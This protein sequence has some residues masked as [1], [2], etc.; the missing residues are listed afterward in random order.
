MNSRPRILIGVYV[1]NSE[2]DRLL[3]GKRCDEGTW[4]VLNKKLGYGETF[5]D[6]AVKLLSSTANILV[7]PERLRFLCTYNVVGKTVH[8]V[9]VDYYMQMTKEEEKCHLMIDPYYFQS[10]NWYAYEEIEKMQDNLFCGTQIFLKKF[11]IK[12]IEDIKNIV[13]N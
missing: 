5:E 9:A 6:C 12:K 10:W 4:S 3:I 7:D 8:N 11:N 1:Y 2:G 13:S